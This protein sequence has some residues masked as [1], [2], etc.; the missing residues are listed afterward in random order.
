M[1]KDYIFK[2]KRLGFR[3]WTE[4]DLEKMF[5]INSDN[6]VM[7]FFP[8]NPTKRETSK[9]IERMKKQYSKKK[10]CYFAVDILDSGRFIGFIG[11]S[12]QNLKNDFSPFVDIGWRL[13]W[14]YWG[15]GF[16]TE[17]AL[18]CLEFAK[19]ELKLKS[20]LSIAPYVNKN[21]VKVMEKIGM[22]KI[23]SFVH[24]LLLNQ[25]RLKECVLYQIDLC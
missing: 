14:E 1:E 18:R 11:L 23:K 12:D 5:E 6:R 9:F 22:L 16:A 25:P 8:N 15:K 19:K 10:Y 3:N 20:I 24:P 13:N 4:P 2:S 21:S 17:G 7:E